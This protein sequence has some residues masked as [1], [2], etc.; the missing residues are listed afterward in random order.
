MRE[1]TA[2]KSQFRNTTT[3]WWLQMLMNVLRNHFVVV[4]WWLC[5]LRNF[6]KF[7]EVSTIHPSTQRTK[8]SNMNISD[9][10]FQEFCVDAG[11]FWKLHGVSKISTHQHKSSC[12]YTCTRHHI[13]LEHLLD[14]VL[15]WP[16]N[17]HTITS[18]WNALQVTLQMKITYAICQQENTL[19]VFF[20]Q[21]N[22]I[23]YFHEYLGRTPTNFSFLLAWAP[24][25]AI[26]SFVTSKRGDTVASKRGD[27]VG[28][29]MTVRLYPQCRPLI[30]WGRS[31]VCNGLFRKYF[32]DNMWMVNCERLMPSKCRPHKKN[33]DIWYIPI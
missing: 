13:G 23:C 22:F 10:S 30:I 31:T 18:C 9:G 25:C 1:T 20:L 2:P 4:C 6:M 27:T 26:P 7:H 17:S 21:S 5:I 33:V 15:T 24:T 3:V 14:H 28:I 12:N 16:T 8:W 11:E 32:V 29:K 19:N